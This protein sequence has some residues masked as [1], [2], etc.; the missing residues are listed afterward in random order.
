MG[1]LR[2]LSACSS[3]SRF[4]ITIGCLKCF[5][6]PR[7]TGSLTRRHRRS[8]NAI[9]PHARSPRAQ[10]VPTPSIILIARIPA[11]NGA[12]H[13]VP[14]TQIPNAEMREWG[15]RFSDFKLA[16]APTLP[17]LEGIESGKIEVGSFPRLERRLLS[18]PMTGLEDRGRRLWVELGH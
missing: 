16:G 5:N 10:C 11:A 13:S 12:M 7:V 4:S 2:S 14:P 1:I 9:R 15:S 8:C 3:A 18:N 6:D 17:S